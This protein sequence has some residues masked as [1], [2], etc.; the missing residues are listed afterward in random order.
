MKHCINFFVDHEL[1]LKWSEFRKSH[2]EF[3]QS[4][5]FREQLKRIMEEKRNE[6]KRTENK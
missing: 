6:D 5:F 2:P 3:N 4:G 1:F